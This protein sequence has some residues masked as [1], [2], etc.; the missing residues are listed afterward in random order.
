MQ[1]MSA[2]DW[3]Q[4]PLAVRTLFVVMLWPVI[5]AAVLLIAALAGDAVRLTNKENTSRVAGGVLTRG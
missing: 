5:W 3:M 4:L 1:N 2:S